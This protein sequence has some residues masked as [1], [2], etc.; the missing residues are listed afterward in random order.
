L[1]VLEDVGDCLHRSANHIPSKTNKN[2]SSSTLS[3]KNLRGMI[4]GGTRKKFLMGLN[5]FIL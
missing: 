3:I 2:S 1:V 4:S 5:N